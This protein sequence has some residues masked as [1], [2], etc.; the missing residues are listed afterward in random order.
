M[1]L[2]RVK[3]QFENGGCAIIENFLTDEEIQ[4]L[5]D[6]M[7][8]IIS[9]LD[10]QK[11]NT[12]FTSGSN[13]VCDDYFM[14]SG[15]KIR[16]FF[17]DGAFQNGNLVVDKTKSVNKVGHALHCL[18][19]AF[20]KVSFSD[21]VKNVAKAIGYEEPVICQSMYIFKQPHIGGKVVPHQDSTYLYTKPLRLTGLWFAL[22]DVTLENGCLWFIPGSHKEGVH[23]NY[24]M[25]RKDNPEPGSSATCHV[26]K[27]PTYEDSKFI[28][29]PV[30]KGT[31][32]LIHGEVVHKSE[33]NY[34][35]KSREIYSFHM[36]DGTSDYAKE[37]WLQPTEAN[38]FSRLFDES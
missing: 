30:K 29:S 23:G 16:F 20:R 2:S 11:H 18:S 26:G 8:E 17:E 32:V 38:T 1:D 4:S 15:D 5:R 12:V 13:Q 6:A 37:N 3:E 25:V 36:Y 10:P 35:D 21:K 27:S 7:A 34:S 31:L 24:R 28:A 33:H 14:T 9:G 22:E 19:P